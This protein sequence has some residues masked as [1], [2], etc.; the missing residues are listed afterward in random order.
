MSNPET[1]SVGEPLPAPKRRLKWVWIFLGVLLLAV[2]AGSAAGYFAGRSLHE[3]RLNATV[4]AWDVDQFVLAESDFH[5]GNYSLSLDRLDAILEN[6]PE[7]PDAGKMRQQVL[8]A[9]NATPTP[10]PTQTPVPTP[11]PDAPRAEQM[12]TRA[13]QQ[14]TDKNYTEMIKTLLTLKAEI[15]GFQPERVDGLLWVGLRFNGVYLLQYT[16]RLMEGMYYLD[17]ASNYAPLDQEAVNQLAAA[18]NF[19]AVY[20][21][22]YYWRNKD[23]E[24]SLKYFNTAI[25]I[26]PYYTDRLIPDYA[27][28]IVQNADEM[29]GLNACRAW[30]F[31]EEALRLMPD[32]EAAAKGRDYA[33]ENC[34]K[35]EPIPFYIE[36]PPAEP[37]PEAT[38]EE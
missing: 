15:P 29:V 8:A 38:P 37:T 35:P 3:Q 5:S 1:P 14:F 30:G 18:R 28:V 27:S 36:E 23:I 25:S 4:H 11:T 31:Y 26:R 2:V 21:S 19:L 17:L 32:Y 33:R 7:Y 13:K 16:S 6:E 24:V 20:Q 10:L 34:D 9:M 22:A 12:L